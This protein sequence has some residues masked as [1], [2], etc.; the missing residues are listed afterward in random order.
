[1]SA[2]TFSIQHWT[3]GF[4]QCNK[5]RLMNWRH[6]DWKGSSKTVLIYRQYN[7]LLRTLLKCEKNQLKLVKEVA[8][9]K[10]T[11]SVTIQK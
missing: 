3:G 9:L 8:R 11:Q 4:N 7:W 10:D 5:A 6:W 1:M 2:P